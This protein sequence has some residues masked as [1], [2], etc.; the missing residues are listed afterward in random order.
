MEEPPPAFVTIAPD[1]L[2]AIIDDAAEDWNVLSRAMMSNR[3]IPS[4]ALRL[5]VATEYDVISPYYSELVAQ[6]WNARRTA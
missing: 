2:D 4:H 6:Q 3:A 5:W 1:Q